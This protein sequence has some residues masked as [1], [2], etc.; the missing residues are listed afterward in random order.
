[1]NYE[2]NVHHLLDLLAIFNINCAYH[3]IS[4]ECCIPFISIMESNQGNEW[5]TS[6]SAHSCEVN[7]TSVV[8]TLLDIN[9]FTA[10][11]RIKEVPN[12]KEIL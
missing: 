12:Q 2:I 4:V 8:S 10:V 7:K 11:N 6:N 3:A 5:H 1:M 9:E